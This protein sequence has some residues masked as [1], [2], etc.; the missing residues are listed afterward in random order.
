MAELPIV[1]LPHS[2]ARTLRWAERYPGRIGMFC[3]LETALSIPPDMPWAIDNGKFAVWSAGKEWD[4]DRFWK[5]LEK[6]ENIARPPEWVVVPDVVGDADKT[7]E[8]WWE[9]YGVIKNHYGF[10]VALA[11]QDGMTP[12]SVKSNCLPAAPDVIFVGGTTQFK[13]RTVR[14]WCAAFPRVHVGRVNTYHRLW[15]VHTAGAES[16]DGTGWFRGDPENGELPRQLKRYLDRSNAG[17]GETDTK[18]LLY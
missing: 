12:E 2:P 11:V 16:S 1:M 14:A 18:G 17:Q 3:G 5:Q 8:E 7:F 10:N 15:T 6:A 13:W 4:E 9:W